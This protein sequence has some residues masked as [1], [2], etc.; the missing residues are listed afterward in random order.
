MDGQTQGKPCSRKK[1][2]CALTDKEFTATSHLFTVR[3]WAEG[4]DEETAEWR[5]QVRH[6]SNGAVHYFRD[7]ASLLDFIQAELPSLND[8]PS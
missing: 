4:L 2:E 1:I 7:W 8:R 6:V 5:G 3:L